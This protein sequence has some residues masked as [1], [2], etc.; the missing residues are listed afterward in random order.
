MVSPA[1]QALLDQSKPLGWVLEPDAKT[2][3][4]LSGIAVPEFRVARDSAE[5]RAAAAELGYPLA[6]KIVSPMILHKSDVGGV[7][8]GI[9]TDARLDQ[10]VDRFRGFE[11][12]TGIHLERMAR[13]VEL[14]LGAKIDDQFGPVIL[15][16]IGGTGVEVYQD[17]TIRMAPLTDADVRDMVASLKGRKFLEGYRGAEKIDLPVLSRTVIAFADLV[18]QIADQIESIDLNPLM[19][20]AKHCIAADARIMLG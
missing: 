2:I 18:L 4:K 6:A 15:L 10:V 1:I 19:C 16:G 9:D 8:V 14:I 12:F 17:I 5:A 7:V 3:L 13:G 11:Q 20:D